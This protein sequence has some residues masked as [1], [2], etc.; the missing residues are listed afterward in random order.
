MSGVLKSS[1][2]SATEE[3]LTDVLN[4]DEFLTPNKEA[5][6]ILKVSSNSMKD[7]GIVEGDMVIVE[8]RAKYKP[9]QLVVTLENGGYK[10]ARLPAR[11]AK[12]VVVEAAIT[13][14]IRKY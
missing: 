1:F 7:E 9:G 3:E 11:S 12:T 13:A 5:S 14:V 10:L 4:W 2:P 8:R 6:Y